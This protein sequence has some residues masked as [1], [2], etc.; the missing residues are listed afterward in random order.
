MEAKDLVEQMGASLLAQ[1]LYW[2]GNILTETLEVHGGSIPHELLTE[3]Q[4]VTIKLAG[5]QHKL[6]EK[7]DSSHG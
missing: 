6:R 3:L 2:A 1:A 5:V 4:D 7:V